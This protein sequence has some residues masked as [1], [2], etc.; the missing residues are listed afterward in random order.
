[1]AIREKYIEKIVELFKAYMKS[2]HTLDTFEEV[3]YQASELGKE[4]FKEKIPLD[5]IV[6]LYIEAVRRLESEARKKEAFDIASFGD[7]LLEM[8]MTYS[9]NFL[10][11]M[12]LRE[13]RARRN[14]LGEMVPCSTLR[15]T[16]LL[17]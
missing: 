13:R 2:G 15:L 11:N 14:C 17:P 10:R 3:R 5:W 16:P 1:M 12:E 9:T 7:L 4:L 8:V 6:G